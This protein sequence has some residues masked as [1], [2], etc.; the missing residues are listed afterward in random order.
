MKIKIKRK[1]INKNKGFLIW[2]TGFSGS[3]KTTIGKELLPLINKRLGNTILIHADDFINLFKLKGYSKSE[4]IKRGIMYGKL[5]KFLTDKKINVIFTVVG[6]FNKVR[7]NNR[8]LIQN[9]IEVFID[10]DLKLITEKSKKNHYVKNSRNIIGLD[11]KPEFP[12]IPDV[13]IFN[14]F[15]TK[16]SQISKKIMEKLIKFF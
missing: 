3:G 1:S 16:P 7:E 13:T 11:I 4:R 6:M 8:K 12:K 2:V 15:K 10:S 9:Y 5:L 14:D